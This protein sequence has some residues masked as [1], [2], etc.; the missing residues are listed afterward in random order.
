MT[1]S[2]DRILKEWG[3]V[4]PAMLKGSGENTRSTVGMQ[5]LFFNCK[6]LGDCI[7][8][9]AYRLLNENGL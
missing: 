7:C 9:R 3:G 6:H 5:L 4:G 2:M 1:T 8:S